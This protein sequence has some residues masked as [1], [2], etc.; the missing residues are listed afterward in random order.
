MGA[1][2]ATDK[3]GDRGIFHGAQK[4][5][6]PPACFGHVSLDPSHFFLWFAYREREVVFFDL[7]VFEHRSECCRDFGTFGK[8]DE[9]GSHFVETVY[10]EEGDAEL[11]TDLYHESRF[12]FGVE[13]DSGGLRDDDEAVVLIQNG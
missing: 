6:I 1:Q 10:G 7:A 8:D 12:L 13:I 2:C 9:T 4:F 5:V 3:L 11:G